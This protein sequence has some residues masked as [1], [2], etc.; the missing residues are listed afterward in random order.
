MGEDI[1]EFGRKFDFIDVI[2]LEP[3]LGAEREAGPDN[4]FGIYRGNEQSGL[5]RIDIV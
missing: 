3:L 5:G 4:L 1:V 2:L